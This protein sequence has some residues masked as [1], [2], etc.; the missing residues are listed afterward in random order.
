MVKTQSN[1]LSTKKIKR[2]PWK[3]SF[4]KSKIGLT[5]CFDDDNLPCKIIECE[6][7]HVD[8]WLRLFLLPV[9]E[10]RQDNVHKYPN[11]R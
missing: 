8:N 10:N 4:S 9:Y 5:E 7:K 2:I 1:I 6:R 3:A 11:K